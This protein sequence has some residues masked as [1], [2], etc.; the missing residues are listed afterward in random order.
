MLILD[1]VKHKEKRMQDTFSWRIGR[2][3]RRFMHFAGSRVK[4]ETG[5]GWGSVPFILYAGKHPGCT[6][7]EMTKA[8]RLDWGH[9][10]RMTKKL[11]EAGFLEVTLENPKK[12]S[13]RLTESGEKAFRTCHSVFPDFDREILSPLTEEE[14]AT[15]F[16][17]LKKLDDKDRRNGQFQYCD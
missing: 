15:L 6:Q 14:R 7:A 13:I 5:L 16:S 12:H 11:E 10:Q 8:L 17:L 9:S 3:C 2:I 1:L 4:D